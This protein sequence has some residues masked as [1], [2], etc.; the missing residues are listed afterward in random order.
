M[1]SQNGF[2]HHS[3]VQNCQNV[4]QIVGHGLRIRPLRPRGR[5]SSGGWRRR[6][7]QMFPDE[8]TGHGEPLP[9]QANFTYATTRS[10]SVEGGK[11]LWYQLS[12]VV[13]FSRGFLPQK[14]VKGHYWGT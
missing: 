2:D 3:H 1:G 5:W 10:S 7:L 9:S 13:Y 14:R 8:P 11:K 4:G 6:N 12:S